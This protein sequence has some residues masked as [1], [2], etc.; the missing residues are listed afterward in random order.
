[1][2]AYNISKNKKADIFIS[3]HINAGSSSASGIE[4]YYWTSSKNEKELATQVQKEVV[5]STGLKSRGVKT[6]NFRVIGSTTTTQFY[7]S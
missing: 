7:S 1:M 5:E 4:T 3:I 6:S 2:N